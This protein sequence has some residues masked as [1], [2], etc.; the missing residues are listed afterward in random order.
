M[1]FLIMM[2]NTKQTFGDKQIISSKKNNHGFFKDLSIN[3]I[4]HNT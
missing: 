2:Y 4:F 3:H 1:I